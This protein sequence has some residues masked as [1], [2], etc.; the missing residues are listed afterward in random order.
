[1]SDAPR[2]VGEFRALPTI[3]SQFPLVFE[4]GGRWEKMEGVCERCDAKLS[5]E[6]LRGYV[7]RPFGPAFLVEAFGLCA[8]GTLTRFRYRFP[9]DMTMVGRSPKS[10]DWSIWG[11][12]RKRSWW[13]RLLEACCKE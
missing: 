12:K 1:M 7:T 13:R 2:T 6:A 5:G 11:L 3:V 9:P 4:T 8:C 10:G